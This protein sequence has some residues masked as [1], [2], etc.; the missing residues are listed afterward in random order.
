MNPLIVAVVGAISSGKDTFC[1]HLRDH[2]KQRGITTIEIKFAD[3]LRESMAP[4]LGVT[5]EFLASRE[6]KAHMF[7]EF[8]IDGR[9][10]HQK[11]AQALRDHF[12]PDVWVVAAKNFY[13]RTMATIPK[14][15]GDV[16]VLVSDLRYPNELEWIR[17]FGESSY[18]IRV[19]R[20]TEEA[21]TTHV[22]E[23]YWS[24]MT[25]DEEFNN[26]NTLKE[27][28]ERA[29]SLVAKWVVEKLTGSQR[30]TLGSS[31]L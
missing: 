23:Q 4:A 7:E 13:Q 2:A 30:T 6:G 3:A 15:A 11:F 8:D 1:E 14:G 18:V 5:A 12:H 19:M 28:N 16:M 29:E 25:V 20:D 26:N 21:P 17:S 10:A 22:S 24:Q 31:E 9:S 27:L